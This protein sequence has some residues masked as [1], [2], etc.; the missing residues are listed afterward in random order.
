MTVRRSTIP[1]LAALSAAIAVLAATPALAANLLTNGSFED[2]LDSWVTTSGNID[3]ITGP[4]WG[5]DDGLYAVDM[6]GDRAGTI[7]QSFDT[8][9]GGEYMVSF[10]LAGNHSGC[11]SAG[12]T[13]DMVLQ[14]SAAGT[15]EEFTHATTA[16]AFG[17]YA[18]HTFGFGHR[19][20]D[21]ARA[22][23]PHAG[24]QQWRDRAHG[25]VERPG[26]CRECRGAG[27][28][29]LPAGNEPWSSGRQDAADQVAHHTAL[30]AASAR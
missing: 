19:A 9:A 28:V 16:G 11:F 26:R 25:R 7:E 18:N 14:V 12:T 2:G 17:S 8:D 20:V 23:Q 30:P 1:I 29:S 13:T 15:S 5:Y 22:A 27:S 24:R 10:A 4:A 3:R 21:G 6:N